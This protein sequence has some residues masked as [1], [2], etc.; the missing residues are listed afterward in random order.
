[1]LIP[2]KPS[3]I[4]RKIENYGYRAYAVGGC[5]RDT[6]LGRVPWDWDI[7]CSA[8]P[9]KIMEMFPRSRPSGISYGTVTVSIGNDEFEITTFRKEGE[10][11][12]GR[13]P[14]SVSFVAAVEE[15]LCRRDFTVNA[16]AAD[17]NGTITDPFGG[18]DDIERKL[19]RCVGNPEK[20]FRED[21]LRM[22]RAVRFSA[23]LG[24]NIEE[25]TVKGILS[26][27]SGALL[28]SP[29]R[30]GGELTKIISSVRPDY[31]GKA[32]N[33]HLLDHIIG[34]ARPDVSNLYLIETGENRMACYCAMVI[35]HGGDFDSLSQGLSLT[36][37]IKRK[38]Y[39]LNK[40]FSEKLTPFEVGFTYGI[41]GLRLYTDM[42]NAMGD[43]DKA[44]RTLLLMREKKF[45]TPRDLNLRGDE[46]VGMGF[47]GEEIGNA[48]KI[49]CH[50]VSTGIVEN[51]REK[52]TEYINTNYKCVNSQN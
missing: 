1:M 30:I 38:I 46:L 49:L 39:T 17:I 29:E 8:P 2:E 47:K 4:M 16:M 41:D 42:L 44:K 35:L 37:N 9:D 28:L 25:N 51:S 3:E 43:F 48:L 22:F 23:C 15:D 10:Y 24:F 33:F 27:C 18:I 52:L 36:H 26:E 12:N 11:T 13:K 20:R 40:I 34:N 21:A 31:V 32:A 7:A 6:L 5:V 50:A 45:I 14:D 19:I